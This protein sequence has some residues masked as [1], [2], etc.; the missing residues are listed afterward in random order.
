MRATGE[1]MAGG[2]LRVNG[3]LH[4]ITIRDTGCPTAGH[5]QTGHGNWAIPQVYCVC[6]VNVP[7]GGAHEEMLEQYCPT[8]S[9]DS[10]FFWITIHSAEN[11]DVFEDSCPREVWGSPA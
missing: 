10:L 9:L 8:Y 3:S 4:S 1:G 11:S 7:V 5:L 2:D 6:G